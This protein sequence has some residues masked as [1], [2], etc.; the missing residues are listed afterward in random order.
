MLMG[1]SATP[2]FTSEFNFLGAPVDNS[3]GPPS[4]LHP[5]PAIINEWNPDLLALPRSADNCFYS[6]DGRI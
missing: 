5:A 6:G 3:A 4:F 1:D 2:M